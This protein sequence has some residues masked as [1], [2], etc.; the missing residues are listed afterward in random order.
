MTTVWTEWIRVSFLLIEN[1]EWETRFLFFCSSL[2]TIKL[3]RFKKIISKRWFRAWQHKLFS[4]YSRLNSL[5]V[6]SKLRNSQVIKIFSKHLYQ[7]CQF[8]TQVSSPKIIYLQ[9][10]SNSSKS[11]LGT[12]RLSVIMQTALGTSMKQPSKSSIKS[13][14]LITSCHWDMTDS[15]STTIV[16]TVLSTCA[17]LMRTSTDRERSSTWWRL[18][19]LS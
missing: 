3:T 7:P 14:W 6:D 19:R 1:L 2:N 10:K 17:R 13:S 12:N 9:F 11:S 8:C 5:V 16:L 18:K 4:W 15:C